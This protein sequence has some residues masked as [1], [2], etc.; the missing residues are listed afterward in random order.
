MFNWKENKSVCFGENF[1]DKGKSIQQKKK[2]KKVQIFCFLVLI[3]K[4][5]LLLF[6]DDTGK[7]IHRQ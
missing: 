6:G 3:R 4:K 7:H 5:Y 2:K 1:H